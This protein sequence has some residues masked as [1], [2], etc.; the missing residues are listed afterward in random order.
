M[1]VCARAGRACVGGGH[2]VSTDII[3]IVRRDRVS[4]WY[5]ARYVI[6]KTVHYMIRRTAGKM[7]VPVRDFVCIFPTPLPNLFCLSLTFSLLRSFHPQL[8]INWSTISSSI[9]CNSPYSYL[10]LPFSWSKR[11]IY[12]TSIHASCDTGRF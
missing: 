2:P 5:E 9:L 6:L 4:S 1:C 12:D 7:Q 10:Y 8:K 11:H 3:G